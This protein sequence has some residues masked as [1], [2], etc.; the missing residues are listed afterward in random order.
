MA[1]NSWAGLC[2][3]CDQKFVIYVLVWDLGVVFNV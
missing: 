3:I 1:I 2:L